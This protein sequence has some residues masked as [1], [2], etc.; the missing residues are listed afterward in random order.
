MSRRKIDDDSVTGV[1]VLNKHEGVTSYRIVQILRK[2]YNTR[3][4]GHTGTLDPMATGVLPVL[5]GRAVKAADFIVAEDKEYIAEMTLG[6][7]T[8]TEDITGEV[9]TRSEQI[10]DEA[11]VLAACSSFAG[12]IEQIPP[13]Y[14][15]IKID[16]QKLV[17]MAREGIVVE[18]QPRPV[19]IRS[20]DAEK[21]SPSVYRLR[22]VCSKGTYIRTLCADIGAKLGCGAVMSSLIRTRSGAFDLSKAYTLAE[23]ESMTEEERAAAVA[24]TESLFTDRPTVDVNDFYAKLIRGGTEL[25]QKKLRTDIPDGEYVRIR[26][27]G[28]F[29]ALGQVKDFPDGSAV[30]PV[31]LFVL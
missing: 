25:Y 10:P 4:V 21:L 28:E 27:N 24:P 7:T 30:K 18:R 31:K 15:A 23:I 20:I 22:V 2:L 12:D 14:S 5:I 19:S 26:H 13:M 29:I 6:L 17:D 16:G 1:L 8:D 11:T 3:K 9:L